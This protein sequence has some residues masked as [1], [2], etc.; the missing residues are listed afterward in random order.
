MVLFVYLKNR[1]K[2]KLIDFGCYFVNYGVINLIII[3]FYVKR[4]I[5]NLEKYS[6]T[7]EK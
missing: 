2:N 6:A 7:E 3:F 4:N 5:V 1:I